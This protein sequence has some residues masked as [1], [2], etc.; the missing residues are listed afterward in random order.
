MLQ[1]ELCSPQ[2][3]SMAQLTYRGRLAIDD[4]DKPVMG[5]TSSVDNSTIVNSAYDP[6]TRRLLVDSSGGGGNSFVYNEIVAGSGNT[7]TLANTPIMG[8]QD[9][10]ANGQH[11][12]PGAGQDYT[13]SGAIITTALQWS[14]GTVVAGYQF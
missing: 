2:R 13:I 12:T 8:M 4:N 10:Y 9:V 1:R 7:W 5:G 3:L 11:L 14:A 6:T